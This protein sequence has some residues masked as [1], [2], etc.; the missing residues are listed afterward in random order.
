ML[1]IVIIFAYYL[2]NDYDSN[3]VPYLKNELL[4]VY[5][6]EKSWREKLWKNG[7]IRSSPMAPRKQ[8]NYVGVEE[9]FFL[10]IYFTVLKY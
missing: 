4:R 1:I 7:I 5:N 6:K 2:Q 10:Y 9:V 8:P 3:A